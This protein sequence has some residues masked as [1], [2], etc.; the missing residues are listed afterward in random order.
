M[1]LGDVLAGLQ[2]DKKEKKSAEKR[3]VAFTGVEWGEMEATYGKKID[4][5][6]VKKLVQGIFK[7]AFTVSKS[8]K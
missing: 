6:D 5:A 1:A 3:Y 2:A 4:P 8:G 7:G